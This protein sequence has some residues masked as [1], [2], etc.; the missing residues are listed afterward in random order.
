MPRAKADFY[1]HFN[2][3]VYPSI[4]LYKLLGLMCFTDIDSG[5]CTV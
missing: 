4:Y 2:I 1:F 3:C 5:D